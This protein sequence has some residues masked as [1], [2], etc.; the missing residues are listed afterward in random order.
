MGETETNQIESASGAGSAAEAHTGRARPFNVAN[1]AFYNATVNAAAARSHRAARSAGLT[2][3]EREDLFQEI[4]C[5]A[6]ERKRWFDPTK[7]TAATFTG[8]TSEHCKADF[9]SARAK[10]QARISFVAPDDIEL[11]SARN[12]ARSGC[13]RGAAQ[14]AANDDGKPTNSHQTSPFAVVDWPLNADL[15]AQSDAVYDLRTAVAFMSNE[16]F[17]LFL[18][19][20]SHEERPSAAKA[21]GMASAT[22]YRRVTDL[23]MHLRMF[24]IRPAA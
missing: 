11:V 10:D 1:D 13:T 3:A 12:Q 22:F 20:T 18:L 21:S 15:F 16:Q 5:D 2:P 6:Y 19:V 7:A 14:K 24:G 9:L 17:D 4:Q 8:V 23:Q